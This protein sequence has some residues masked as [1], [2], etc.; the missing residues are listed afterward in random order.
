MTG[1]AGSASIETS[2][3]SPESSMNNSSSAETIES[4][5]P[6]GTL[7]SKTWMDSGPGWTSF[8]NLEGSSDEPGGSTNLGVGGS[9]SGSGTGRSP[10]L[11]DLLRREVILRLEVPY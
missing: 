7:S 3:G 8:Y 1:S 10:L 5:A 6:S 4:S 2:V 9:A 11:S